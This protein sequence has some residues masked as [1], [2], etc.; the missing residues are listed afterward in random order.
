ME[1]YKRD[2]KVLI[3]TH[4]LTFSISILFTIIGFY[5]SNQFVYD[6]N[7]CLNHYY[8]LSVFIIISSIMLYI[9]I[10]YVFIVSIY[11]MHHR[12]EFIIKMGYDSINDISNGY[13][14]VV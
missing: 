4:I 1:E 3:F 12:Y 8:N 10:T 13:D 6:G 2:K 9:M 5:F 7:T 14:D 11:Q